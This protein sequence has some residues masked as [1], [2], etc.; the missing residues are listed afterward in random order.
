M[1]DEPTVPPTVTPQVEKPEDEQGN[2]VR[3][4]ETTSS[5]GKTSAPRS[6]STSAY[7]E[8]LFGGGALKQGAKNLAWSDTTNGR[9]A[10]RIVSRG[11][12]G[13]AAFA[14]G[15]RYANM[16]LQGYEAHQWDKS[17]PL[18]WVAKGFDTVFGEPIKFGVRGAAKLLGGN[19]DAWEYSATRFR[20]KAYFYKDDPTHRMGRSLGTEITSVS[21]DFSCMSLGDALARNVIQV[22]DPNIEKPWI[23]DG[24]FNA[25]EWAKAVG[26]ATWRSVS[27]N[28]G[29]DWAVALPYV[30]FMK[31]QRQAI[32]RMFPGSKVMLDNNW[33]GGSLMINHSGAVMGDYQLAGALDLQGRFS[34]YNWFTLMYRDAYDAI[35]RNFTQ[36]SKDGYKVDFQS[37]DR[38]V[39]EFIGS[40]GQTLRYTMK[41]FIKA[42]LYMQPAVPFFWMFRTP[43]SKW[44][45]SPVC[46]DHPSG[47]G[48][49]ETEPNVNANKGTL[50]SYQSNFDRTKNKFLQ[51]DWAGNVIKEGTDVFLGENKLKAADYDPFAMKNQKNLFS[52]ML[53]PFGWISYKTGSALIKAV[54]Q[55][56]FKGMDYSAGAGGKW[57]TGLSKFV[58]VNSK[59]RAM[60][61]RSFVDAS[62]A[63]TPYFAAKA[64]LGLRV[65]DRPAGGGLGEMDKAIYGLIDSVGTFK[66]KDSG[67]Y[68][69][70]VAD[71]VMDVPNKDAQM[72]EADP[73]TTHAVGDGSFTPARNKQPKTRVEKS[74]IVEQHKQTLSG[75]TEEKD[76]KGFIADKREAAQILPDHPTVQ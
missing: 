25:G 75:K 46:P 1:S 67:K 71:L 58:G 56:I 49:P 51:K 14:I 3:V 30:Y 68:L 57:A 39:E 38:P 76:W 35:H 54:E 32:A 53:N 31:W 10:I 11:L 43:Q 17:K 8:Y 69:R 65:D 44:K 50:E 60:T 37:S 13:A 63:Y 4:E 15:S 47:F 48:V 52:L 74:S 19:A 34:T 62:F 24:K 21:F 73:T 45:A 40:V 59:D 64:E 7:E 26:R 41:S 42:N 6:E 12:F 9:I 27:K 70:R 2:D 29:E 72:R 33:N 23:K 55:P 66:F 18:H 22:L 16:N 20:T 5:D 61:L 36:W 28:A